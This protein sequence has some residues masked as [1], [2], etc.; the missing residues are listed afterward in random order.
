MALKS[1]IPY[2]LGI[3]LV[4]LLL[5]AARRGVQTL[6]E[7][8]R[9]MVTDFVTS[10]DTTNA[11]WILSPL[12][13][14]GYLISHHIW[15]PTSSSIHNMCLQLVG[16]TGDVTPSYNTTYKCQLAEHHYQLVPKA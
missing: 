11:W 10:A 7:S 14:L 2:F 3:I 8:A 9:Q 6:E 12:T 16:K 4:V 1:L 5:L 13:R 15:N